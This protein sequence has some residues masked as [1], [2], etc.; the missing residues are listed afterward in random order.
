MNLTHDTSFVATHR[1]IV[2]AY[3]NLALQY[4]YTAPGSTPAYFALFQQ[5]GGMLLFDIYD[6]K[7]SKAFAAVA[8]S[9]DRLFHDAPRTTHLHQLALQSLSVTRRARLK[10]GIKQLDAKEVGFLNIALPNVHGEVISLANLI[11]GKVTLINFIAYASEWS[12]HV[13]M[14]LND[15]HQAFAS[16]GLLI[17]QV[18]LDSD[19]HLWRNAAVNAPWITVFDPQSYHSEIAA[20]YAVQRLPTF[21]LLDRQGNI[22]KRIEHLDE[23]EKEI[24]RHL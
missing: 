16:K 2:D 4:I 1:Q 7:D 18:S 6:Q 5:A 10:N 13:N 11:H 17:Y 9:F 20:L 12:P 22:V 24:P 23:L 14:K 19:V 3:K 8:T 21:F 15:L